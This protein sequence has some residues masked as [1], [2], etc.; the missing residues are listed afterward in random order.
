MR[1]RATPHFHKNDHGSIYGNIR[2]EGRDRKSL[3]YIDNES[4]LANK[5]TKPIV[6]FGP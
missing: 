5:I 2:D 4:D 1:P 6:V 3:A